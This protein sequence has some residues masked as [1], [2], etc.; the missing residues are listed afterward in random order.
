MSEFQLTKDML[1][2]GDEYLQANLGTAMAL[3]NQE[4]KKNQW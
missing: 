4:S 1:E 2:S 3:E